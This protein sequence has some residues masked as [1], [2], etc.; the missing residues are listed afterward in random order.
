MVP[1]VMVID[2]AA[3]VADTASVSHEGF[4]TS[5]IQENVGLIADRLFSFETNTY[6]GAAFGSKR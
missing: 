4:R 2:V 5:S 1:V 3:D 6:S